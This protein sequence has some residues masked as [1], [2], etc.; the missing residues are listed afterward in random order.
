MAVTVCVNEPAYNRNGFEC[1]LSLCRTE[2]TSAHLRL[3]VS[4]ES[5]CQQSLIPRVAES[6]TQVPH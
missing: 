4:Y 5:Q 3:S 1:L 2:C 6:C